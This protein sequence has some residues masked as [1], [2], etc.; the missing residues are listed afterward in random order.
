[1]R[2]VLLAQNHGQRAAVVEVRVRYCDEVE[3]FGRDF[4]EVRQRRK[5]HVFR[6]E[7]AVYQRLEASYFEQVSARS[8]VDFRI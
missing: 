8:D 3:R 2:V 7:T 1:M 4:R 6:V 5:P